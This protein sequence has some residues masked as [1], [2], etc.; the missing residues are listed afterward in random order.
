MRVSVFKKKKSAEDVNIKAPLDLFLIMKVVLE[1]G[2]LDV[3]QTF[4]DYF[5][6]SFPPSDISK[7]RVWRMAAG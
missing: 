6:V 1:F 5:F 4:W 3:W 2:V 7:W